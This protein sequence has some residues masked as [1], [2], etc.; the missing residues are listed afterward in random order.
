M[1]RP[2][3]QPDG[4]SIYM[5]VVYIRRINVRVIVWLPTE[6]F[7]VM[8]H[9]LEPLRANLESICLQLPF[10]YYVVIFPQTEFE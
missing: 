1:G 3:G 4:D 8:T 9:N 5:Q 2:T 6:S 10:T 7:F